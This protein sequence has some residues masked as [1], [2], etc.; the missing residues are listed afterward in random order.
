VPRSWSQ[1]HGPL[2]VFANDG[3][4]QRDHKEITM[5]GVDVGASGGHKRA[6]NSDIN[7]IPF[8]DLLMCTIAFLLITAVWVT[9]A[10]I[11]ADAQAPGSNEG[12]ITPPPV[13]RVLHVNVGESDFI[14]QWK[15]AGTVLSE[16]HVPRAGVEVGDVEKVTRY[17]DLAQA[18]EKEWAKYHE[19]FDA[20]D[21]K[22]DQL[23]L[24]SDNRTPFRDLVAVLDA[25]NATRRDLRA[26]DGKVLQVA[27]FNPTFAVR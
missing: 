16:L 21:R 1:A 7:M 3:D 20:A 8:I 18:I 2:V 5:A 24:H 14:L 23:V 4:F 19:H 12:P 6:T 10:R 15:H 22:R 26:P 11:P 9:S 13:E 25:A 27:A 17:P